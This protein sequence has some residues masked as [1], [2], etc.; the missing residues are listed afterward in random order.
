MLQP[1]LACEAQLPDNQLTG[2]ELPT[3]RLFIRESNFRV[4]SH[5]YKLLTLILI[6]AIT[7]KGKMTET[8]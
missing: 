6:H 2:R 8:K 1:S 3:L 7:Q 4:L 5:H